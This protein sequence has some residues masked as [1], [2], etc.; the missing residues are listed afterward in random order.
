MIADGGKYE[1]GITVDVDGLN[2]INPVFRNGVV[3]R[4][5]GGAFNLAN[6][7][8]DGTQQIELIG[9]AANTVAFLQQTG[10]LQPPKPDAIAPNTPIARKVEKRKIQNNLLS[11]Y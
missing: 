5:G 1:N 6:A 8:M 9:A 10:A 4:Y 3:L 2:I 7:S 11:P